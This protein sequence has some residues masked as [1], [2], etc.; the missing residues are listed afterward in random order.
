MNTQLYLIIIFFSSV[1]FVWSQN[2]GQLDSM[3]L[4]FFHGNTF[5]QENNIDSLINNYIKSDELHDSFDFYLT[6]KEQFTNS[7]K[8]L[9]LVR[10][11]M[12]KLKILN[13]N[14]IGEMMIGY[15]YGLLTSFLDPSNIDPL[16]VINSRGKF[17]VEALDLPLNISFNYSSLKNPIGIN[18]YFRVSFDVERLKQNSLKHQNRFNKEIDNQL[19]QVFEQKSLIQNKLGMGEVLRNQLIRQIEFKSQELS[20]YKAQIEDIEAAS[21]VDEIQKD[22]YLRKNNYLEIKDTLNTKTRDSLMNKYTDLQSSYES[23]ITLYDT[24]LS[25]YNKTTGLY[26]KYSDLENQLKEKKKNLKEKSKFY[27]AQSTKPIT[28]GLNKRLSNVKILDFGLTYPRMSALS[29]NSIPVQGVNF[30]IQ[31]DEWYTAAC[32]GVAMNNLSFSSNVIDNSLQNT[33]NLFNQFDFQNIQERGLVTSVKSGYGTPEGAHYFF[34]LRYVSNSPDIFNSS[35]SVIIP[36]LAS[37]IDIRLMPKFLKGVKLDFVFGKTS[38]RGSLID[39]SRSNVIHS[40]LSNNRTNIGLVGISKHVSLIRTNFHFSSRWIDP[41]ADVR[42]LGVLQPN[43]TRYEFRTNTILPFGMRFELNYRRDQNNVANWSDTTTHLNLIGGQLKGKFSKSITY[44]GS[45]NYLTQNEVSSQSEKRSNNFMIGAGLSAEYV[46]FDVQNI[47]VLSVNDYL[48]TNNVTTGFF[49]NIGI[50]N[51]S[52]FFNGINKISINYFK[53]DDPQFALNTSYVASEEF[54]L[55]CKDFDISLGLKFL[56]SVEYGDD[57]GG[58]LKFTYHISKQ[59]SWLMSAEKHV[60]GDFYNYFS[61]ERF[62]R[63]P[64]A[65]MTRL[66]YKFN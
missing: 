14:L 43:N 24:I 3:N 30:E 7:N 40:V 34:G 19:K 8:N 11:S 33:Q 46:V 45:L 44:Y 21:M 58:N 47:A 23:V 9:G 63:F 51:M 10:D 48:I 29:K 39:G 41:L 28:D 53:V 27:N 66:T 20:E 12:K 52:R 59:I 64:Y 5:H 31:K 25:L 62:N 49:R 15:E 6:Q 2:T 1:S 13:P 60:L 37:E 17:S 54:T 26:N 22:D 42:S 16:S 4:I 65:I 57:V 55:Q 32:M 56:H 50:Q 61:R 35:D 36:S 38:D 18:N